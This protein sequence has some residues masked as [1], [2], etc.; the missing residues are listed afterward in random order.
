[1]LQTL[2][3]ARGP[4]TA[5]VWMNRPD[6]RNALDGRMIAELTDVFSEL[7]RDDDV[8]AIVL[9]ARGTA[10]CAGADLAWLQGKGPGAASYEAEAQAMGKLLDTLY[11]C[12]KPVIARIHGACMGGGMGLAAVCDIAVAARQAS[13]GQPETRLGLIP[14][15]VAPYVTRAMGPRAAGRWL[16]TGE[17]FGATEAWRLGLVH[18]LC[19]IDELDPRIN[20]ML[21]SFMLANPEAVQSTKAL[22]RELSYQPMDPQDCARR[23]AAQRATPAGQEGIS[24]FLEKRNPEWAAKFLEPDDGQ[25]QGPDQGQA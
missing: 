2:E 24:A 21:G 11:R 10:F 13:F 8:Q 16:L 18:D 9:A 17:P 3:L 5:V 7:G 1:M 6:V 23:L 15:L 12:P 4:Q 14:A 22:V 19:E 25:A 20:A